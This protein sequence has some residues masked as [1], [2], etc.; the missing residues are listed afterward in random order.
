MME[1]VEVIN[2]VKANQKKWEI[3]KELLKENSQLLPFKLNT[4][5]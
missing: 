1:I 4:L 3:I 2:K 5:S